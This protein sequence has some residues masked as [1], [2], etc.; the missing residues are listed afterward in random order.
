MKSKMTYAAV[1]ATALGICS[2]VAPAANAQVSASGPFVGTLQE[3][4][5]GFQD[6]TTHGGFQASPTSVFGGA[7]TL[8]DTGSMFVFKPSAGVNFRL[9]SSGDDAMP[10]Q[11]VQG[12]GIANTGDNSVFNF[13]TPIYSFGGYFG[14]RTGQNP[15]GEQAPNADPAPFAISFFDALNNQI[16]AT[17]TWTYSRTGF[18]DGLLEWH[19]FISTT[20]FKKIVVSSPNTL[21]AYD[22]L[23]AA[24]VPEPG[25]MVSLIGAGTVGGLIVIRRRRRQA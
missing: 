13:S 15:H 9:W 24:S 12:M 25:V 10:N 2:L 7:A 21:Y 18:A 4:F 3:S 22:N 17:Q 11:G 6:F 19:G 8:S 1:L 14:A 16:G 20:G 5:E 23:Q